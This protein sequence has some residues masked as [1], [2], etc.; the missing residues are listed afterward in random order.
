MKRQTKWIKTF[1]DKTFTDL[2]DKKTD[3]LSA[4]KN[5][6]DM[7]NW[8]TD[9]HNSSYAKCLNWHGAWKD[10]QSEWPKNLYKTPTLTSM[11]TR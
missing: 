3:K 8:K 9:N 6:I 1:T 7:M 11:M 2:V 10:W 5:F 4:L